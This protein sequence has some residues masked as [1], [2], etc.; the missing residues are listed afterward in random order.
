MTTDTLEKA[1]TLP[2]GLSEQQFK[3][4]PT[5]AQVCL[6]LAPPESTTIA[7]ESEE[8]ETAENAIEISQRLVDEMGLDKSKIVKSISEAIHENNIHLPYLNHDQRGPNSSF[9]FTEAGKKY[10]EAEV[11]LVLNGEVEAMST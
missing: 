5:T 11:S 6:K 7:L 10:V 2:Y 4:L 3:E 8:H 9:A 1:K